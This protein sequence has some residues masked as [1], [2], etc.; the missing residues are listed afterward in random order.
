MD[1]FEFIEQNCLEFRMRYSDRRFS[2]GWFCNITGLRFT[3]SQQEVVVFGPSIITMF[4]LFCQLLSNTNVFL[5]KT[6][7]EI[8]VPELT[9]SSRTFLERG[10]NNKYVGQ[11]WFDENDKL[12]ILKDS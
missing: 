9:F 2:K 6:A 12:C 3:Q 10:L 11:I 8:I 7:S 4:R 1:L 5:D